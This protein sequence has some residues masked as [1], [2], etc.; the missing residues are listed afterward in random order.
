MENGDDG[1]TYVGIFLGRD[2]RD[3]FNGF[4]YPVMAANDS[5]TVSAGQKP[6]D[7]EIKIRI[8]Y[9][10]RQRFRIGIR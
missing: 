6:I 10:C 7:G 3:D 1:P 5:S 9:Q 8:K 4:H 2:Q